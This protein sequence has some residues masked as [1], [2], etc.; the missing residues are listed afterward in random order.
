MFYATFRPSAPWDICWCCEIGY[1]MRSQAAVHENLM[2]KNEAKMYVTLHFQFIVILSLHC[3][4]SVHV[5][6]CVPIWESLHWGLLLLWQ[7]VL[8][9]GHQLNCKIL[10]VTWNKESSIFLNKEWWIIICQYE[11]LTKKD[12]LSFIS[13][14]EWYELNV[15]LWLGRPGI[16]N[17]GT[18]AAMLDSSVCLQ[19]R[20]S[21]LKNSRNSFWFYF[22]SSLLFKKDEVRLT[23]ASF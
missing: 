10:L 16:P 14:K 6:V 9:L 15:T 5:P 4:Q 11:F 22:S 3:S 12:E 19:L 7:S 1:L 23:N 8:L 2:V 20:S 18:V 13:V 21:V 17:S